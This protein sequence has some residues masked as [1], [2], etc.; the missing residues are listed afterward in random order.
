LE[1]FVQPEVLNLFN[2]QGAVGVDTTIF[3]SES[4]PTLQ[5]FNPLTE[6]P[7]EGVHWRKGDD[8][9]QPTGEDHYQRPRTF[10]VSVGLRF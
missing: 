2:E 8:F 10:R 9:G 7:A 6:S 4:D 3:T 1:L 5:L